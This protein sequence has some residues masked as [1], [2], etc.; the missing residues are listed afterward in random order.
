MPQRGKVLRP[1]LACL[2]LSARQQWGVRLHKTRIVL[3]QG[4]VGQEGVFPGFGELARD[5]AVRGLAHAV[6]AGR[7]LQAL[8]P[9][10]V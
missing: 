4:P 9:P 8:W 7:P 5:Q 3:L 1:L 10:L 6:V 2:P